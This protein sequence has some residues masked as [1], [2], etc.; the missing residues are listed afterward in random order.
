MA[1]NPWLKI[2]P[3]YTTTKNQEGSDL[4]LGPFGRTISYLWIIGQ[5]FFLVLGFLALRRRGK[6]EGDFAW[7]L[8]MPVLIS[9]LIS[10]GTIGDHRFRL[11][12]MSLSLILQ[13]VGLL[14]VSKRI[15]KA[16]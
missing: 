11:P 8:I 15:S 6:F 5:V 4:V 14:A 12:T 13:V 9:W 16:T 1:R 2:S 7:L 10:I 3:A